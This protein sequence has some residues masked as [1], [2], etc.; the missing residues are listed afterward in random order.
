[1]CSGAWCSGL[2]CGPVKAETAGSN[3]VAPA[4]KSADSQQIFFIVLYPIK[5]IVKL[6]AN[7]L[8]IIFNIGFFKVE[9]YFK[10]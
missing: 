10:K 4:R 5:I 2:T 3:P 1:M 9:E 7:F 8:L 6:M